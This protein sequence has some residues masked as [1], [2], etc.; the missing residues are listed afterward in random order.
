MLLEIQF[1]L[2]TLEL[3]G[4]HKHVQYDDIVTDSR[5]LNG[6]RYLHA[7]HNDN[8]WKGA[9]IGKFSAVAKLPASSGGTNSCLVFCLQNA[10]CH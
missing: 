5:R 10:Q 2:K 4:W 9:N 3:G 6:I 8:E 7:L 1:L